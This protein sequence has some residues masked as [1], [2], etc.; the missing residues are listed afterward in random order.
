MNYRL[1]FT[2]NIAIANIVASM[3]FTASFSASAAP[4]ISSMEIDET[5]QNTK[6][7]LTGSGFG[8]K[9]QAAPIL[10]DKVDA[11]Y[12][13]GILNESYQMLTDGSKVPSSSSEGQAPVWA[14]VSSGAWG[15]FPPEITTQ[16][17]RHDKSGKHYLLLG[18]NS[19]IGNP[20][21]YGGKSG[22]DTP[23]DNKQLYVSWWFKPKYEPQWYWRVSP[24]E[25]T[26]SF[27]AEETLDIGGIA[28]ATFIGIDNDG[29]INL[30][31]HKAPP[32]TDD[33]KGV[34]IKG[35]TSGATS[36]FPTTF[37]NSE[38]FGYETPGSQKYIRVWE[39]P[40]GKEGIRFSWTQMHQTIGSTVNWETA[41][42]KGG[43]WNHLEL[44]MDTE[45]GFVR[46]R[47]NS[48]VLT[49]FS[50]DPA[51]DSQ[52]RWS[53]TV[54][55]MGLN[56]KVGKLQQSHMDDIYIDKALQRVVVG[57]AS[58]FENVTHYEVQYPTLWTNDMLE[59]N[60]DLGAI[61]S[62]SSAYVYVFDS[63]GIQNSDGYPL[64]MAMEC[65]APPEKIRL[66][67]E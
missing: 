27:Q 24:V 8:E 5:Q 67:V 29:Q 17:P 6:V 19:T 28:R 14:G 23:I 49:S 64:C 52:G 56:G 1:P 59:F 41:P 7:T 46:L 48:D 43:E 50:F 13:N 54:A 15:S 63:S 60:L 42:V 51:L 53:P 10:F 20:V 26:G 38:G 3:V 25:L 4:T 66:L 45:Q 58:K 16:S 62:Q 21:A 32:R 31:F 2:Q 30:V 44:E 35:Q 57:N 18:H 65:K 40:Y 34:T 12:E 61:D 47:V 37:V 22:W 36:K 9:T 55:L 11:S 33:L 39:D